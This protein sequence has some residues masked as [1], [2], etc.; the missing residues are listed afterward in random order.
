MIR[1]I[2]K[3]SK[4]L[5][6]GINPHPGS[7]NRS[8]PFSNNKLFWY[9]LSDAGMLDETRDELRDD[10][11]LKWIYKEKFNAVYRLGFI[12]IIDRPTRDVS[13]FRKGEERPGCKR[14]ARI[15][16]KEKPKVVCFI[17]RITYEK[18]IASKEFSFGWQ[19]SIYGSKVFV[20]H[21]PLRGKA[22]VRVREL[23]KIRRSIQSGNGVS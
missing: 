19:D 15:I 2:Y 9:L 11:M 3:R 5:F 18:Y 22:I 10:E 12:N 6:V 4:I 23:K 7:F 14:V 20:M 21:F 16:K 13:E 1:Y 8:V 17:G